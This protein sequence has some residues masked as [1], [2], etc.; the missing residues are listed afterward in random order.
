[1][2]KTTYMYIMVGDDIIINIAGP[3]WSADRKVKSAGLAN[4]EQFKAPS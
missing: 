4:L 3:S 2:Y 1:M